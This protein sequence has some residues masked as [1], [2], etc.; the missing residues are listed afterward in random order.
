MPVDIFAGETMNAEYAA[1]NPGL[2]TPVLELPS[3]DHLAESGAILLHLAEGTEFLP[4]DA[5]ERAQV[6]RWLFF[7]QSAVLPTV[8]DLRFRLHTGRIDPETAAR[9]RLVSQGV[10]GVLETHLSQREFAVAESYTIADIALFGYVHT[11]GEADIDMSA[12]PGIGLWTERVRAQPGHVNDL[13]PYPEN[14]RPGK[15]RSI[16][17]LRLP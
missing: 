6:Y 15:S 9:L 5:L 10:L 13:E 16:H 4:E 1:K 11:A 2:T 12:Y 14:A 7:E 8:A 17:D 3:G